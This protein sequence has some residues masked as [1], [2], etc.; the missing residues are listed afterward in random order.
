MTALA[1]V[2]ATGKIVFLLK[3]YDGTTFLPATL[4]NLLSAALI[5][6]K[7]LL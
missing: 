4:A 2:E 5:Q 6:P 7:H 1:D 3:D